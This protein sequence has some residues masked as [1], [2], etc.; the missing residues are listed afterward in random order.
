MRYAYIPADYGTIC[1][2]VWSAEFLPLS[3]KFSISE[4]SSLKLWCLERCE[5]INTFIGHKGKSIWSTAT[6]RDGRYVYTGGNDCTLRK[7]DLT[8][9]LDR[10]KDREF[11]IHNEVARNVL[12]LDTNHFIV[13]TQAGG[14]WRCNTDTN[15]LV[16]VYK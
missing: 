10:M 7:W 11:C 16:L 13:L 9:F 3:I 14:L 5:N 6:S 2:R 15:E 4:D 12:F 1:C 8:P